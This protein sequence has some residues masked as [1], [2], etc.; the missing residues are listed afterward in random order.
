[1]ASAN[2]FVD[3][4]ERPRNPGVKKLSY[5][6]LQKARLY[7]YSKQNPQLKARDLSC[8][9]KAQFGVEIPRSTIYDIIKNPKFDFNLDTMTLDDQAKRKDRKG[10]NPVL[11]E[12]LV[13]YYM[14][15]SET[16]AT[17]RRD[18][19][20]Q[21]AALLW[22]RI[23]S[24]RN[25]PFPKLGIKWQDKFF[26]RSSLGTRKIMQSVSSSTP[27][28][29]AS[30]P[31]DLQRALAPFAVHDRFNVDETG[32]L[33]KLIPE[34]S[35]QSQSA[36]P[37]PRVSLVLA[38]NAD[39]SER[40]DIWAVGRSRRPH[41]FARRPAVATLGVVWRHDPTALV[42]LHEFVAYMYW[43][44]EQMKGRRVAL[45]LTTTTLHRAAVALIDKKQQPLVNTTIVWVAPSP[46]VPH[47]VQSFNDNIA[48]QPFDHGLVSA[49]KSQWRRLWLQ[50][51][52]AQYNAR[53]PYFDHYHLHKA[54][55]WLHVAWTEHLSTNLIRA[56]FSRA[57]GE[58]I[59]PSGSI[60]PEIVDPAVSEMIQALANVGLLQTPMS[61]NEFLMPVDETVRFEPTLFSLPDWEITIVAEEINREHAERIYND[62]FN[63]S[64][65][66]DPSLP[67]FDEN[68][69]NDDSE[70]VLTTT[71]E[72]EI[73]KTLSALAYVDQFLYAYPKLDARNHYQDNVKSMINSL[74]GKLTN[75]HSEN[76]F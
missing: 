60:F 10:Q 32:L 49:L 48:H 64:G 75:L 7:K 71:M 22:H 66:V 74:E 14:L 3:T 52:L 53:A 39:A 26:V 63:S 33:W 5:S 41:S 4:L 16:P 29:V 57:V 72:V 50:Y 24:L 43:F 44:D 11:E 61:T 37:Q 65:S 23:D 76:N 62:K 25:K 17:F 18:L 59:L 51:I 12:A 45:I 35:A 9:F 70:S 2:T 69:I 36:P 55:T 13:R 8:W 54:L 31:A 21:K 58:P 15:S 1:M 73:R 30:T 67:K 56:S 42:T 19:L 46:A 27:C 40:L 38:C 47:Q 20:L 34:A 28:V 68:E 6:F